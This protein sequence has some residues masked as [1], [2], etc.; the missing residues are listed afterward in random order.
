VTTLEEQIAALKRDPPSGKARAVPSFVKPN[1][2]PK[3]KKERKRREGSYSRPREKP[4]KT[5]G[6]KLERCPDCGRTLSGGWVHRTRQVIEI[7]NLPYEVIEHQMWGHHCGVCGKD[8]VASPDLSEEVRGTHRFGVRLTS[9][10]SYLKTSCRMPVRTVQTLLC[11]VYGLWVSIGEIIEILHAVAA[12]GKS[13]YEE[14]KKSLRASAYVHADETG[15]REAGRNGYLWS[16]STADIRYFHRDG[17]RGHLV[18][19]GVLGEAYPGILVSDFYSGYNYHLGLHQRCWV[20]YLRDLHAL[21]EKHPDEPRVIAWVDAVVGVYHDARSFTSEDH[22]ERVHAREDFQERLV[23]LGVP[24]ARTSVAQ[25]VLAERI[26]RH[27]QELFTF[28]E[29]TAVP[30]D[31]NPAERAIRPAVIDRKVTGG[32]RSSEGSSTK[33]VLMSLFGTWKAREQD[34]LGACRSMLTAQTAAT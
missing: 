26:M 28:V 20:H 4:T 30:S 18:A 1:A 15:L 14:L 13:A 32:T 16:F 6:H 34:V 24:Y 11:S 27:A 22:R 7:P 19:E 21:K 29:H 12:R 2:P 25:S 10:V 17:S 3:E 31:N 33:A 9:L 5:V 23:A 8:H